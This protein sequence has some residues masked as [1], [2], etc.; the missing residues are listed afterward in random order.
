[1][2]VLHESKQKNQRT[3]SYV[4]KQTVIKGSDRSDAAKKHGVFC[5]C[6]SCGE[7]VP[8]PS[9]TFCYQQTCSLCSVTL[10]RDWR[11]ES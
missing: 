8:C 9:G 5:I 6:P 3:E 4:K 11:H 1:M 10:V 7:R 2:Q